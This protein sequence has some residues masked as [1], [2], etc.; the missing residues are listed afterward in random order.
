MGTTET[1]DKGKLIVT[2]TGRS[3][4]SL[5]MEF[6]KEQGYKI[7]GEFI[8]RFKMGYEIG[9]VNV[10]NDEIYKMKRSNCSSELILNRF[11]NEI[12]EVASQY[13]V[14]KDPRFTETIDIWK[15]IIRINLLICSIRRISEVQQS[16]RNLG[17]ENHRLY[18]GDIERRIYDFLL[19]SKGIRLCVLVYPFSKEELRHTLKSVL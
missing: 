13:D 14:L 5:I 16:A 4:T 11:R 12:E 6:L 7:P 1:V 8:K 9:K 3:G 19:M 10:I 18:R 15:Q 17:W 2:G